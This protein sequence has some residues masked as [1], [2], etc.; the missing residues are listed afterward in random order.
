MKNTLSSNC[1][2]AVKGYNFYLKTII[3]TKMKSLRHQIRRITGCQEVCYREKRAKYTKTKDGN[4]MKEYC[5]DCKKYS[6]EH[7]YHKCDGTDLSNCSNSLYLASISF[8]M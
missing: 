7:V 8:T 4:G 1:D 2:V 5:R 6:M 3:E